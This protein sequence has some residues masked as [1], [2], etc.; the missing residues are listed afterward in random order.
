MASIDVTKAETKARNTWLSVN[1]IIWEFI[2]YSN[3][4]ILPFYY[5]FESF[6]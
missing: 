3:N 5:R 4:I 6:E 1:N 2:D